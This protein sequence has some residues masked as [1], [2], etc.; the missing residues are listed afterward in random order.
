MVYLWGQWPQALSFAFTP[1]ALY[2][3]YRY[4]QS[5]KKSQGHT[6]EDVNKKNKDPFQTNVYLYLLALILASQY[7]FHPQGL[8]ASVITLIFYTIVL[9]VKY[10]KRPFCIKNSLIA[11]A[12]FAVVCVAFAPYN[13]GEFFSQLTSTPDEAPKGAQ[14]QKLFQWYQ[15]IKNDP[16]LPD[17]YF[18]YPGSHGGMQ[19]ALIAWW[20]LPLL[21]LGLLFLFLKRNDESWLYLCFFFAFYLLTRLIV[22]G[23]GQ[24]DIR[25][26]AFEAHV[27]YPIIALGLLSIPSF[28]PMPNLK[29]FAK[30]GLIVV[31]IF[32]AINVNGKMAYSVLKGMENSPQRITPAQFEAAEWIRLNVPEEANIYDVGTLGFEYF[33]GKVKWFGALTQ[34]R[35]IINDHEIP[36]ANYIVID[37][38][39][40]MML[41]NQQ[42]L[43]AINTF[44]Q[45][46]FANATPV[47]NSEQIKVYK[48]A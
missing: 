47:Y 3:F 36:L 17:F 44:E 46:N 38:S 2:L 22:F 6:Q 33:S 14:F 41:G 10:K 5:R 18:S 30:Y 21:L 45:T 23:K 12:L 11:L 31:F 26:F 43:Q 8:M 28:I 15:G 48:V 29:Q 42:Y 27:F 19:D 1:L 16:G 32:L 25:M 34:R 35:I 4:Q 13:L 39:D 7:F 40:G 37:Y 20:T 9:W 24:K